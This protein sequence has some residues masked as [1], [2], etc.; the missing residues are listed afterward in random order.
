MAKLKA[1]LMS[2]GAS[3]K[4]AGALVYFGWKGLD[5]VRQYVIPANPKTTAQNTQRGYLT[6]VVAAIHTLE[7]LAAQPLAAADQAAYALWGAIF[8]TPRTWFNQAC[9]Q[10]IKQRVAAKR[11]AL[12][13][14]GVMTPTS[15]QIAVSLYFTKVSGANDITAGTF[16]YGTSKSAL[17]NSI[18]AT[19]AA[20]HLTATITPLLNGTKYYIQ[21][22]PSTH[23]DYVGAYSGIYY[24]TPHA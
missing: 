5:V 21:F 14:G 18:A 6:E 15:G 3:G 7:A 13:R 24:A 12:Y 20:D 1:P 19:V 11:G 10:S 23:A 4:L 16:Y 9:R 8:S 22:R 2:L 17:I